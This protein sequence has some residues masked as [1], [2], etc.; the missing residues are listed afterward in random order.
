MIILLH[1]LN[2]LYRWCQSRSFSEFVSQQSLL[3]LHWL[4]KLTD[5]YIQC[6]K[7]ISDT[8]QH[9]R[10]NCLPIPGKI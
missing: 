9:G 2:F 1:N 10:E 8:M 3:F 4:C 6:Y 7:H 5:K